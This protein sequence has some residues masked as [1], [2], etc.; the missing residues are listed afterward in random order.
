MNN[1]DHPSHYCN[2]NVE[3]IETIKNV[4]GEGFTDYCTGNVIKYI[5]RYKYKGGAED[6]K[7]AIKYL[8]FLL[9]D[10][11]SKTIQK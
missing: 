1:V 4:I 6:I 11:E 3:T 8:E 9:K 7:K 5:S 10:L 2:N